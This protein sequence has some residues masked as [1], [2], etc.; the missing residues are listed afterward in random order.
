MTG[1]GS[2]KYHER[3]L[4]RLAEENATLEKV[5]RDLQRIVEETERRHEREHWHP[6]A[7]RFN[8]PKQ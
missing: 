7:Q 6:G 8:S 3:E 2:G 4:A 1:R 5:V